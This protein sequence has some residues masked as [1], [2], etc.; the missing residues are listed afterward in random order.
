MDFDDR[1]GEEELNNVPLKWLSQHV[2]LNKLSA[3]V[4]NNSLMVGM[5][6]GQGHLVV[7]GREYSPDGLETLDE[8]MKIG[9]LAVVDGHTRENH[10]AGMSEHWA[11]WNSD[12]D[13][14][15]RKRNM[16]DSQNANPPQQLNKKSF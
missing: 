14:S 3:I 10:T 5:R 8:G 15:T 7:P 2:L 16:A 6:N 13:Y 9:A 11:E 1:G 4:F 12:D